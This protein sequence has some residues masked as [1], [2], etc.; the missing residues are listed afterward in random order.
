[1]SS[2]LGGAHLGLSASRILIVICLISAGFAVATAPEATASERPGAGA[3]KVGPVR[4]GS[5]FLVESC[6]NDSNTNDQGG[7][8]EDFRSNLGGYSGSTSSTDATKHSAA[9]LT[10]SVTPIPTGLLVT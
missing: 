7:C 8:D 5:S 2:A 3:L 10:V 1:M 9:H 6:A 4:V